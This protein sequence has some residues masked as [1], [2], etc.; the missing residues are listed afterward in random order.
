[1]PSTSSSFGRGKIDTAADERSWESSSEAG[2]SMVGAEEDHYPYNHH[3]L[4]SKHGKTK[5]RAWNETGAP[6]K[7]GQKSKSA[8]AGAGAGK[9]SRGGGPTTPGSGLDAAD[10]AKVHERANRFASYNE[11]V[12]RSG[13]EFKNPIQKHLFLPSSSPPPPSSISG[14]PDEQLPHIDW[15]SLHIRGTST[16]L[17]KRYL[18]LT[19]AP[20]PSTVRPE[21]VLQKS[22]EMVLA[23]WRVDEHEASQAQPQEHLRDYPYT[24]EQ[25]KSI[26]QDLTVQHLVH[27]PLTIRTYEEHARI[28]LEV[29]DYSEYN[30]CQ[31][32]LKNLYMDNPELRENA[33]EF[34]S[35]RILYHL[36]TNNTEAIASMLKEVSSSRMRVRAQT[37]DRERDASTSEGGDHA[38]PHP[39]TP[40]MTPHSNSMPEDAVER[41]FKVCTAALQEDIYHFFHWYHQLPFLGPKILRPYAN[42]IRFAATTKL[43]RAFRPGK[44]EVDFFKRVLGFDSLDECLSYLRSVGVVVSEDGV[45][46]AK[47]SDV[48]RPETEESE[49]SAAAHGVTHAIF[50][51]S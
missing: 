43:I 20:D 44:I 11:F 17:E 15:G 12:A 26:R 34:E 14:S 28:A 51:Q 19:Q 37:R 23:K 18:R 2:G 39:P 5:K 10:L 4:H 6:S 32:Q 40:L 29:G 48:R 16:N 42:K 8:G 22:L 46:D 7:D 25:L 36:I 30:Q 45:V 47:A 9:R 35:Y 3:H 21:H 41:A 49:S 24:C 13:D 27:S 1:M 50:G 31:T 38:H 33:A